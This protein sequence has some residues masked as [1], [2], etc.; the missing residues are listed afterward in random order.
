MLK[1][2]RVIFIIL[3]AC[4]TSNGICIAKAR[5]TL[6]EIKSEVREMNKDM[7]D[8]YKKVNEI[9]NNIKDHLI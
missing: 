9:N 7:T 3:F 8:L 6:N 1:E 5:T 4:V 2:T